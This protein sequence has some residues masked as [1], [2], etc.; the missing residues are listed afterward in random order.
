MYTLIKKEDILLVY[1]AAALFSATFITGG[2]SYSNAVYINYLELGFIILYSII[3][4]EFPP[5]K[6]LAKNNKLPA[7]IFVLWLTSITVSLIFSPLSLIHEPRAIGRYCQT[8]SHLFTFIFLWDYLKR[9]KP[10][11]K[12]I[13]FIIPLTT[14]VI[15]LVFL[16]HNFT[17]FT[18]IEDI[19]TINY[20]KIL[21]QDP[22]YNSHIRHTGYQASAGLGVLWVFNITK[23]RQNFYTLLI[24]LAT[25]ITCTFVIWLGGRGAILSVISSFILIFVVL[26]FQN[27]NT[28]YF[29]TTVSLIFLLSIVIAELLSVYQWNGLFNPL[30]RSLTSDSINSLS[31]GRVKIWATC[32][33]SIKNNPFWGLGSQGYYYMPNR[34]FGVQPHNAFI[35]FL[36]E[37]GIIGTSLFIF[38]IFSGFLAGVRFHLRNRNEIISQQ[39]LIALAI[40]TTLTI[41]SIVDGTYYHPQPTFYLVIAFAVWLT[42]DGDSDSPKFK[43]A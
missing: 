24:I 11:L 29:L 9:Y 39:A 43:P 36:V 37:W 28:K 3:L 15:A 22:P 32:W 5:F 19:H 12:K 23:Q 35:Q 41:H 16:V 26:L 7:I 10:N 4:R 21:F 25:V 6:E 31:S 30:H 27:S 20:G 42:Y 33:E 2:S 1:L 38:L 40:I 17:M 34:I 14:V 18:L 13:L 8:I